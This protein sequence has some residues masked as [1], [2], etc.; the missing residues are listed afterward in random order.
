M[1]S[2][3]Q[4]LRYR[5]SGLNVSLGVLGAFA[6]VGIVALFPGTPVVVR[7]FAG[8]GA[9]A[10]VAM[11]WLVLRWGLR[12]DQIRLAMYA[13]FRGWTLHPRDLGLDERFSVFPFQSGFAGRAVNVLRGPHRFYDA[14]TFTFVVARPVPQ[15]Y[16]VTMIELG[17]D[18]PSFMLLPED[19][20][21]MVSKLA[22]GQDI[23][24]GHRGF[25]STWRIVATDEAFVRRV[26]GQ[27]LVHSF[28]RKSMLGMPIAVDHG[29]VLTWQA[30]ITGVSHLSR[31]LD[32]LIEVVQAIPEEYWT[33]RRPGAW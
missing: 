22:G 24:I 15:I 23:T 3:G 14:A 8:V 5:V 27:G 20:V 12:R 17:I 25:D 30:G 33:G 16:Q 7:V 21:A 32:T 4:G 28:G 31:C 1:S 13:A 18:V 26:L 9:L 11:M 2:I 10:L 19:L 29:A 6:C